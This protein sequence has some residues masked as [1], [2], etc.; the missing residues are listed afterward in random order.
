MIVG[1]GR[2]VFLTFPSIQ[3][4][5]EAWIEGR[6]WTACRRSLYSQTG[7]GGM[8]ALYTTIELVSGVVP[9]KYV[10]RRVIK[11]KKIA[12]M[13]LNLKEVSSLIGSCVTART[14]LSNSRLNLTRPLRPSR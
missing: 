2:F 6:D 14:R 8:V 1:L 13:N 10:D 9:R 11:P 5:N 3:C 4:V 12:T 7:L